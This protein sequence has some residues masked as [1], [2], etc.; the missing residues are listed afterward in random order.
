M[1]TAVKGVNVDATPPLH[2]DTSA[3]FLD[4]HWIKPANERL[5]YGV[6]MSDSSQSYVYPAR[7]I[8]QYASYNILNVGTSY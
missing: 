5:G 4:V 6:V 3:E 2:Y 1:F 7:E 8:S